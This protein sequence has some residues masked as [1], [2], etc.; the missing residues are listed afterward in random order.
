MKK[1][2]AAFIIAAAL[3]ACN[4]TPQTTES[5]TSDSTAAPMDTLTTDTS[6]SNS[7]T[8]AVKVDTPAV[9]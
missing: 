1:F 5:S 8:T 2:F 3:T 9:K 6:V 4:D 7:D